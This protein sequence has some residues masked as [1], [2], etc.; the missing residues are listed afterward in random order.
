MAAPRSKAK[1]IV[2]FIVI[3]VVIGQ[4]AKGL[5]WLLPMAYKNHIKPEIER[6]ASNTA[7][8]PEVENAPEPKNYRALPTILKRSM[9]HDSVK[10]PTYGR[11]FKGAAHGDCLMAIYLRDGRGPLSLKKPEGPDNCVIS[12][13]RYNNSVDKSPFS[14]EDIA[15]V[16]YRLGD[17][18]KNF[19]DA[20]TI[21]FQVG[22]YIR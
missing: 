22:R 5:M 1:K 14:Y 13:P 9:G 12:G 6:Y 20:V 10:F 19:P 4:S 11:W 15:F 3:L 8:K 17:K 21:E 16:E 7:S 2:R 18:A